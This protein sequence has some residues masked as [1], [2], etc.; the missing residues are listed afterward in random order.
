MKLITK[1][2]PNCGASLSFEEYQVET[3]CEY[4]NQKIKI[5][6]ERKS[7]QS[8]YTSEDG[9][10]SYELF[11]V[12]SPLGEVT[13]FTKEVKKE[14]SFSFLEKSSYLFV[15]VLIIFLFALY[16]IDKNEQRKEQATE[17]VRYVEK[18]SDIDPKSLEIF[19]KESIR[20]LGRST[21]YLPS[22]SETSDWK[23]YGMY[24]LVLD[25]KKNSIIYQ[26]YKRQVKVNEKLYDNYQFVQ[27]SDLGI[28]DE[29][30]VLSKFRGS[31]SS[32]KIFL[33]E[34]N[35]Y[36]MYGYKSIEELYD[37]NI[38][39]KNN[40]KILATDHLYVE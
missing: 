4:C 32:Q 22:G 6:K 28:S 37:E 8:S 31:S 14:K 33:D 11:V 38:S 10:F 25:S 5:K 20:K 27:Y 26:I 34:K 19:Q 12:S 30:I 3:T 9:D 29:N 36:Y 7:I 18:F 23:Y 1:K 13:T 24:L 40:Y 35:E 16:F 2:C 17:P 21:D 15:I 39:G